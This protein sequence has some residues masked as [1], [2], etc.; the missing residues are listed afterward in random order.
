MDNGRLEQLERERGTVY[1]PVRWNHENIGL[2]WSGLLRAAGYDIPLDK[3]IS[4]DVV[5]LMM[6]GLKTV[7]A[8]NPNAPYHSDNFDD[9]HNYLRY[10]ARIQQEDE[11]AVHKA[12]VSTVR[13]LTTLV[14]G[15][16]PCD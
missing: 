16:V 1:G 4:A 11:R 14:D 9:G 12:G 8:A 2:V 3:P 13:G 5:C 6:N 10:A 15:P 7:R